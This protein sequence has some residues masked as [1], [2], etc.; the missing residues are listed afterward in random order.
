MSHISHFK[1]KANFSFSFIFSGFPMLKN[2]VFR[3]LLFFFVA[4]T[5]SGCSYLKEFQAA[6]DSF[7]VA[8]EMDNLSKF[9]PNSSANVGNL[10][11]TVGGARASYSLAYEHISKILNDGNKAKLRKDGL[12]GTALTIKALCEWKL[13]MDGATATASEALE[14]LKAD[15]SVQA[16]DL[17]V[18]TALPGLIKADQAYAFTQVRP[19]KE[20]A[21]IK[22]SIISA[23]EDFK[24]A[25][26]SVDS[27][28]N[29]QTY[30]IMSE[31]ALFST[32]NVAASRIDDRDERKAER[33]TLRE[34]AI[35]LIDNLSD[36][37]R[38]DPEGENVIAYWKDLLGIT[39]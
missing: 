13:K 12:L 9:S 23:R 33:A 16:R 28:H 11:V 21:M 36:R 30:L 35:D 3:L 31:L 19:K 5:L 14:V 39:D 2:L 32:W 18:L 26:R 1:S 29:V 10:P 37:L 8:A 22:K 38:F 6:Q 34:E 27:R 17:A 25:K 20:F 24:N 7:N 4:G 15:S